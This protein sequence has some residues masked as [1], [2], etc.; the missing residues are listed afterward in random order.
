MDNQDDSIWHIVARG[1]GDNTR[2]WVTALVI[3][4]LLYTKGST[5]V[6]CV[7][8]GA[9]LNAIMAKTLKRIIRQPRPPTA[10]LTDPGMPSSHA[11]SLFFL[12]SFV[13]RFLYDLK[14]IPE[15][16]NEMDED[17]MMILSSVP[18]QLAAVLAMW[19]VIRGHHTLA[20]VTVG[21]CLGSLNGFLWQMV[22]PGLSLQVDEWMDRA[23][24]KFISSRREWDKMTTR[25]VGCFVLIFFVLG[26]AIAFDSMVFDKSVRKRKKT[27]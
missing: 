13:S 4:L 2:W 26:T 27:K 18:L 10:K 7:V 8:I 22:E 11:M 19:R 17:D 12:A 15:R 21:G 20:Q 23:H 24:V 6:V 16:M 25:Y 5:R 1:V 9:L 3:S 14:K